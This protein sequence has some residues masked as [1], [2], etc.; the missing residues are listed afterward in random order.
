LFEWFEVHDPFDDNRARLQ[1]LPSGLIGD[2]SVNCDQAEDVGRKIQLKLNGISVTKASIKRS[3][4][5]KSLATTKN[6]VRINNQQTVNIDLA[7]LF[8]RLIVLVERCE[9]IKSYFQYELTPVP[10]SLFADNMMRKPNKASL[11]QSLLGKDYQAVDQEEIISTKY[12]VVDGGALLRKVIWKPG[13]TFQEVVN[14]YRRYVRSN[15]GKPTIIFDGYGNNPS[16]KYHEHFRRCSKSS[17]CPDVTVQPEIKVSLN[18]H[19]FLSNDSNK[20]E[21]IN[22][23]SD[24]LEEDGCLVKHSSTDADTMID[25]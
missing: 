24:K 9:V 2:D 20:S 17:V 19:P 11:V 3:E 14:D 16:T 8:T 6:T 10:T 25:C 18:Q 7:R 23:I 1:S 12:H 22:L 21:L 4:H 15:Y 13:S 5:V